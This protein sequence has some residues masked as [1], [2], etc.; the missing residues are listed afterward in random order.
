MIFA[1]LAEAIL[2]TL[3]FVWLNPVEWVGNEKVTN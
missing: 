2:I 3:N 1:G